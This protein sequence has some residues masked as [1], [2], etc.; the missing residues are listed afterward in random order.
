MNQTFKAV[1]AL[2]GRYFVVIWPVQSAKEKLVYSIASM[3]APYQL[4]ACI[5]CTRWVEFFFLL[6]VG[7]PSFSRAPSH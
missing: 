2:M 1:C 3:L 6:L 5:G 4:L 7:A